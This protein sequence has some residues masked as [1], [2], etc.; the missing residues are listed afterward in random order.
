MPLT[1]AN[2]IT[3]FRFFCVPIFTLLLLYYIISYKHG[4]PLLFF[5]WGATILFIGTVI[6][7]AIDGYIARTRQQI[8]RLG[9]VLD[10]LADKALLLS[11]LIVLAS[12][13]PLV[14]HPLLPVWFVLLV[15]SRDVVLVLGATLIHFSTGN[16]IVRPRITGKLTTF[17]Q[18]LI[19][20]WVLIGL[21]DIVFNYILWIAA[22]CTLVS[23][24]QYI[25]DGIK[26]L[27]K[28]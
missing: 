22:S 18:M 10:P 11:G 23:G 14:F 28:A 3:I 16:V 12:P 27:E 25:F 2:R 21:S 15:I 4:N 1:L 24:I 9:T 17:F 19:I 7:D 26:Q 8:T 5:R 20:A 13:K 6:L